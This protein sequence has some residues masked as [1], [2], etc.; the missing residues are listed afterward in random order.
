MTRI[1]T[2]LA[3]ALLATLGLGAGPATASVPPAG[4]TLSDV[5]VT[6]QQVQ[7]TLTAQGLPSGEAVDAD[8]V[9]VRVAGVDVQAVAEPAGEATQAQRSMV[10]LVDVSGSMAG[11]GIGSLK[12]AGAA[13]LQDVPADVSVGIVSFDDTSQVL[14]AP[15]QDRV[16][17]QAAVEGLSAAGET[18]LYDGVATGLEA[19]GTEGDR[20]LVILSDGGDTA[21]GATIE[22]TSAALAASGARVEVVGF[23]TDEGQDDILQQ[24]AESGGGRV[25]S[26]T[27]TDA[28]SQ[29]FSDAAAVLSSQ[30][31]VTA[32]LPADVS[33]EVELV[34]EAT[35]GSDE[36]SASGTVTVPEAATVAGSDAA[37]PAAVGS[38]VAAPRFF[39]SAA[40]VAVVIA[41][42]MFV[43]TLLIAAPK[44]ESSGSRRARQLDFYTV[45]GRRVRAREQ[46]DGESTDRKF[47]QSFLDASQRMVQRRGIEQEMSM[48]LDQADLP[49][50]PHEWLVLRVAGVLA[51][52]AVVAVLGGGLVGCALA[53]IPGWLGSGV[54]RRI[55]TARRLKR[56][57][58]QLPDALALVA[59]SL[60]TGFSLPQALDAVARDSSPPLSNEFGRAIAE[61]RLGAE[62]EDALDRVSERM[63]NEDMRWAVMAM[64]IQRKVGGNL[65]ETLRSTIATVRE[66]AALHRHVKALSAEGRLSAYILIALPIG[67]AGM[68]YLTNPDYISQLWQS[69]IGW[70]LLVA[71]AIGMVVGWF[72]MK[73]VVKVEV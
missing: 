23:R 38:V 49:F 13:F 62:M 59:S 40:P 70:L 29:A 4:A 7:V 73:K 50:R 41:L 11:D 26:A 19:L 8:S 60:Q 34:V 35:A 5:V 32:E 69:L 18:A 31:L 30:V 72:W 2:L 36:V 12:T 51:T 22:S 53:V 61:A 55:R 20:T 16:A 67:I 68:M 1:T 45:S 10:L 21:S 48:R 57:G 6:G 71:V 56:F 63:K 54:Y 42:L 17:A 14:L 15:T 46:L 65:A 27:D 9:R 64:R 37:G 47:G 25:S 3:G 44:L 58:V 39:S 28:L 24:L 52:V 33:G 66:R 43:L